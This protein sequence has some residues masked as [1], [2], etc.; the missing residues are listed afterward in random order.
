MTPTTYAPDIRREAREKT[1]SL[2]QN[3]LQLAQASPRDAASYLC[4]SI[5]DVDFNLLV[6]LGIC[7][8]AVWDGQDIIDL[9]N[10]QTLKL[11]ELAGADIV[12]AKSWK[13]F[14]ELLTDAYCRGDV[15]CGHQC[16][17][18]VDTKEGDRQ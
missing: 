15:A 10:E 8:K 18:G 12:K 3:F 2:V 1:R 5:D 13:G 7:A 14:L 11:V 9:T 16:V 6:P 4:D 17:E